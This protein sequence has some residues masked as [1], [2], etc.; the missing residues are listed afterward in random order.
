MFYIFPFLF[1]FWLGSILLWFFRH[2]VIGTERK[3]LKQDFI[4]FFSLPCFICR[5]VVIDMHGHT[6]ESKP[7]S[8]GNVHGPRHRGLAVCESLGRRFPATTP[9]P[10]QLRG[11]NSLEALDKKPYFLL[12]ICW[13]VLLAELAGLTVYNVYKVK[14][15]ILKLYAENTVDIQMSY[16]PLF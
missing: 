1:T 6:T 2:W 8:P 9:S 10:H 16:I 14:I 7:S 15:P 11:E 5:S 3:K 13:L 4:H 12:K